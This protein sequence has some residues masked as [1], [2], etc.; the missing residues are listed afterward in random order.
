LDIRDLVRDL[1]EAYERYS[2]STLEVSRLRAFNADQETTLTTLSEMAKKAQ[3]EAV[4]SR[5][6]AED[7]ESDLATARHGI[8]NIGLRFD[9]LESRPMWRAM[10]LGAHR[11]AAL[12]LTAVQLM[13]G[14][15]FRQLSPGLPLLTTTAER[16]SLAG[17]FGLI[18]THII[19][20][21][22][23]TELLR[24]AGGGGCGGA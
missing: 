23:N 24:Q 14:Q 6:K 20:E 11:G 7:L 19:A 21:V 2:V 1:A 13:F 22:D 3:G 10:S 18:A 5:A 12:S 9:N 16:D 17:D 8:A 15:D 4:K